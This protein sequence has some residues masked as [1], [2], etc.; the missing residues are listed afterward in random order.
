MNRTWRMIEVAFEG[1]L[2]LAAFFILA[3]IL[4]SC[5]CA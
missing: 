5:V 4:S 1:L 3:V 2:A